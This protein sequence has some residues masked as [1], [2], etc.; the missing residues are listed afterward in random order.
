MKTLTATPS[1]AKI[2]PKYWVINGAPDGAS[3]QNDTTRL[4]C[5][6]VRTADTNIYQVHVDNVAK[7]FSGVSTLSQDTQK[8]PLTQV[9]SDRWSWYQPNFVYNGDN[10]VFVNDTNGFSADNQLVVLEGDSQPNSPA[11]YSEWGSIGT[12]GHIPTIQNNQIKTASQSSRTLTPFPSSVGNGTDSAFYITCSGGTPNNLITGISTDWVWD[13]VTAVD[14]TAKTIT[15]YSQNNTFSGQVGTWAVGQV[16]V[17]PSGDYIGTIS[18]VA[19]VGG[20]TKLTFANS[21]ATANWQAQLVAGPAWQAGCVAP[22]SISTTSGKAS[23]TISS[24]YIPPYVMIAGCPINSTAFPAGTTITGYYYDTTNF[25]YVFTTSQ[26][27]TTTASGPTTTLYSPVFGSSVATDCVGGQIISVD[28]AN[29]VLT[30]LFYGFLSTSQT[31]YDWR[32]DGYNYGAGSLGQITAVGGGANITFANP[33][34]SGITASG[35]SAS[36]TLTVSSAA[37]IVPGL[38][39]FGTNI[40]QG[41]SVVSVNNSGNSIVISA[42]P[43]GT[44]SSQAVS[45]TSTGTYTITNVASSTT[46]RTITISAGHAIKTGDSVTISG[47]TGAGVTGSNYNGTFTV[48]GATLTTFTYTAGTSVTQAT[49]AASG[50]AQGPRP[51]CYNKIATSA[52]PSNWLPTNGDA[53]TSSSLTIGTTVTWVN[54]NGNTAITGGQ[55][56]LISNTVT[57][58]TYLVVDTT[59]T[60]S[61]YSVATLSTLTTSY[62]VEGTT[63][64]VAAGDPF[65]AYTPSKAYQA[66]ATTPAGNTYQIALGPTPPFYS[67]IDTSPLGYLGSTSITFSFPYTNTGIW[68]WFAP[69]YKTLMLSG[70]ITNWASKP[71]ATFVS[72]ATVGG[73]ATITCDDNTAIAA[74]FAANPTSAYLVFRNDGALNGTSAM[75]VTGVSGTNTFTV[76]SSTTIGAAVQQ[77]TYANGDS[78]NYIYAWEVDSN[79]NW[80]L[81]ASSAI[82][83]PTY[84]GTGPGV[85]TIQNGAIGGV[86]LAGTTV[87]SYLIGTNAKRWIGTTTAADLESLIVDQVG[88]R[89]STTLYA[90]VRGGID[91]SFIVSPA[92]A[93]VAATA[94]VAL[95]SGSNILTTI[96]GSGSS[97][98]TPIYGATTGITKG[99]LVSGTNIPTGTVVTSVTPPNSSV[100]AGQ[101]KISNAATGSVTE[102][103]TFTS[104]I[105][106]LTADITND[107][108]VVVIGT[109]ATQEAVLLSGAYQALDGSTNNVPIVWTLV[110]GNSFRFDHSAGEPVY[111]PNVLCFS[112]PLAYD[113]GVDTPVIGSPNISAT[114]SATASAALIAQNV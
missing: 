66:L 51:S 60:T 59:T 95:S 40:P 42:N 58:G 22:L 69:Y 70:N 73:V 29:R 37:K 25:V 34:I 71:L 53:L 86:H 113:H 64:T 46:T 67:A 63:T 114:T 6:A 41:T 21:S 62:L 31:F 82:S 43:T 94:Q 61:T 5:S 13:Y 4:T 50:T 90:D 15:L 47:V 109:G 85:V 74:Y 30:N 104:N 89:Y 105:M 87:G 108:S 68:L 48:T 77:N 9:P 28:A 78:Q 36:T 2:D 75:R 83:A 26:A 92:P 96:L 10:F 80:Q 23:F 79:Y 18:A 32:N 65:T 52:T 111:T 93:Q 97:G 7:F 103:V 19:T 84:N 12:F 44:L 110:A 33:T 3:A 99:M 101:I 39:I 56:F 16:V 112:T 8:A 54:N 91:T 11:F 14:T 81:P 98:T 27:A 24:S 107:I 76:D 57:A 17:L 35:T 38:L 102:T 72:S 20:Y 1:N 88:S 55:Y 45:F 49:T 100:T 106:N